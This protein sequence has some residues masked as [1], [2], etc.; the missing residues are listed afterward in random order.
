[1][2][3][4]NVAELHVYVEKMQWL[5]PDFFKPHC[6]TAEA[7]ALIRTKIPNAARRVTRS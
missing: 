2:A 5:K 4:V 3:F 7:R 6:G 1:V